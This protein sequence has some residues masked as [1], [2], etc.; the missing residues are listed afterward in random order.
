MLRPRPGSFQPPAELSLGLTRAGLIRLLGTPAN[1]LENRVPMTNPRIGVCSWSLRAHDPPHLAQLLASLE[2]DA[3]Q[4]AL[5]PAVVEP[6]VWSSAVEVLSAAGVHVMSGM[7]SMVGED[8]ASLDSIRR[9][10]GVRPDSTWPENLKLAEQVARQASKD[11]IGLVTCHAGFLDGG[12]DDPVRCTMLGRLRTIVDLFAAHGVNVALETGQE[13]AATLLEVFDALD[14][15]TFGVNFDPANMILYGM[16]DPVQALK[17]LSSRVVQIHVKDAIATD[18]PGTWGREVA[19][20]RG[21]V[22]WDEF[23]EVALGLEPPVNF[24][25][26]REA[27]GDRAADITAARTLIEDHLGRPGRTS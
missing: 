5:V 14:R 16:G 23:F 17:R 1:P 13:T 6:G 18:R 25:I 8:Y 12:P 20:G 2:I 9:T 10:G 3:V 19:T 4:L 24:V 22:N 26:E 11:G 21:A 7:L 15:P 27:G